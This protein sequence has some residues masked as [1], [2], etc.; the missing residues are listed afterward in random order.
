MLNHCTSTFQSQCSTQK[1]VLLV[2]NRFSKQ[3]HRRQHWHNFWFVQSKIERILIVK[4]V[5]ILLLLFVESFNLLE[6]P[7]KKEHCDW[8]VE[9]QWFSNFYFQKLNNDKEELCC[10]LLKV[11]IQVLNFCV[12]ASVRARKSDSKIWLDR[13]CA[14]MTNSK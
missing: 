8:N 6:R 3:G 9:V 14:G 7:I 10:C 1:H 11:L 13:K 12:R 5:L 4:I 2:G